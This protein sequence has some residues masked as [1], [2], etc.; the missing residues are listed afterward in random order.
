MS[1]S[2]PEKQKAYYKR[3]NKKRR[4]GFGYQKSKQQ[5]RAEQKKN[6]ENLKSKVYN[7]YGHLC[8]CCGESEEMFLTIDHI[9]NDGGKQRKEKNLLG[10]KFYR[11]IIKNDYPKNLRIMCYNCNSGRY[12]NGGVCPHMTE[13]G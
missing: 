1:Y 6:Y 7:Y 8:S 12:R 3:R 13:R 4:L 2:D 9:D 5:L 11:W 10:A